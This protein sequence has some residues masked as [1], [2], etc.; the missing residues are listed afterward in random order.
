MC[1]RQ[2][3]NTNDPHRF[4]GSNL[5][6]H[7]RKPARLDAHHVVESRV[8]LPNM[9]IALLVASLWKRCQMLFF[10][11]HPASMHFNILNGLETCKII[12][13][14]FVNGLCK[15]YKP[16]PF[17]CTIKFNLNSRYFGW[18]FIIYFISALSVS[19][20]EHE[21]F[22]ISIVSFRL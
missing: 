16:K 14:F 2:V 1:A 21:C 10:P 20:Y 15:L 11:V 22:V 9:K 3:F 4:V 13:L 12:S 8:E 17:S 18:F 19:F 5:P 7:Y 6:K